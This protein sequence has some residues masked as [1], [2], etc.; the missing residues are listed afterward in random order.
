MKHLLIVTNNYPP[1]KTVGT[2]RI[3]RICKFLDRS[4][5]KISVLTLKENYYPYPGFNRDDPQ[6]RFLKDVTVYRTHRFDVVNSL[7]SFRERMHAKKKS[8]AGSSVKTAK[9]QNGTIKNVTDDYR[10]AAPK[11]GVWQKMKDM[12]TDLLQFPDSN[13]TWLPV[14]VWQGR[15][16]IKKENVD[17]IFS[18]SPFSFLMICLPWKR[19][20]CS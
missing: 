12:F 18:T 11:S 19:Q 13:I 9:Q 16:I 10:P 6:Y 17:V 20:R 8:P 15:Q 1:S 4:K 7:I 5:W 14:A 2:Q 3:L